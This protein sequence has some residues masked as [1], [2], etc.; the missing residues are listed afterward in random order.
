MSPVIEPCS[1]PACQ[2]STSP[3]L[4]TGRPVG[5]LPTSLLS[6]ARYSL[7]DL[8]GLGQLGEKRRGEPS[9]GRVACRLLRHPHIIG[10]MSIKRAIREAARHPIL[11]RR[12]FLAVVFLS[13]LGVALDLLV[14][15]ASPWFTNHPF[16]TAFATQL[17]FFGAVYYGVDFIVD[18]IEATRWQHAAAEPL[19]L[20]AGSAQNLDQAVDEAAGAERTKLDRSSQ[21]FRKME[22][23]YAEFRNQVNRYQ[24][25]LTANPHLVTYLSV[26]VELDVAA[27][28]LFDSARSQYANPEAAESLIGE[29]DPG[30]FDRSNLERYG[31]ALQRFAAK[32]GEAV[33]PS[34]W[35]HKWVRMVPA[36]TLRKWLDTP[37]ELEKYQRL[38]V[39][40]DWSGTW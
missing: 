10:L 21:A 22:R 39:T 5:A 14:A 3:R 23:F 19:R 38:A 28:G 8:S 30:M 25:L 18:T 36:D 32:Y 4:D 11:R 12:P 27:Q 13:L 24:A 31:L 7:R 16:V 29:I 40:D 1:P 33:H 35:S 34:E 26:T 2:L 15:P 6:P 20:L 17:L 9:G 37:G